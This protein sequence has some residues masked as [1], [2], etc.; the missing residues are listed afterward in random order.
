MVEPDEGKTLVSWATPKVEAALEAIEWPRVSRARNERQEHSFKDMIDH[1]A[2]KTNSGR[3]TILGPDRHQQRAREHLAQALEVAQRR[4]DKQ[5]E[6]LKVPQDHVVESASKRH[7]K[8][9]AQRQRA[10]AG[11]EKA[12]KDAQHQ[13]D[14]LAEHANALGPPRQR[15]DR[16]VRTQTIMT[17]RTLL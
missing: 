14:H 15:A 16:D 11:L 4:V 9:L 1:G 8:R 3:K 5:A 12:L 17:V 2:L 7:G 13:H 6:A 10:S